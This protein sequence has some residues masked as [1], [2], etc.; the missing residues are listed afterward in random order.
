MSMRDYRNLPWQGQ[1]PME[2]NPNPNRS[3]RDYRNQ[4]MS[5]PI[6]SVPST[7]A[8]PVSPYYALTSQQQQ[9][10]TSSP[11]EQAILNLSKLVDNFIEDQRAVNFQANQEIETM[12]SSLNKELDVFQSEIDQEFDIL[13]QSISYQ[14]D[15]N[16]KEEC[17]NETILGE[18]AQLQP[19]EGLKVEPEKAPEEL[20]DAPE[21]CVVYGPWRREQE[22]LPLLTEEAVEECQDHNLPLPPID[23]VYILPTPAAHSN[24][25]A[26]T[27][28]ATPFTLSV[29]QKI[30]KLVATV[31][32]FATTSKTLAATHVAWHNGWSGCWFE[33]GAPEPRHL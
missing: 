3:M 27:I 19:Q 6:Y 15:E 29:L 11:V 10:P 7:Y 25:E 14:E 2:R 21:S 4:W 28:K 23:S 16:L 33:F 12:E 20:Q 24:L 32:A 30:R 22:I 13:Q 17:L 26:P 31:R 1:Q 18:Q 9:P 8:P 5:A